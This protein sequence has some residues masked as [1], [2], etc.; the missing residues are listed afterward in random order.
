M[1][2][3]VETADAT[4]LRHTLLPFLSALMEG[5]FLDLSSRVVVAPEAHADD[6]RIGELLN[7]FLEK[8]HAEFRARAGLASRT[9]VA[10]ASNSFILDGIARSAEQTAARLNE[11][12]I[13]VQQSAAGAGVAA[14]SAADARELTHDVQ[15]RT[16]TSFAAIGGSLSALASPRCVIT[17]PVQPH[18]SRNSLPR[19]RRSPRSST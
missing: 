2:F 11:V 7:R 16:S 1:L 17:P 9:S 5:E 10:A 14:A 18:M 19:P 4:P 8:V 12:T 15:A 6:R 13:E 3:S